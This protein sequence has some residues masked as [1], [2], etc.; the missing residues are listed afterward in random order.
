MYLGD[1]GCRHCYNLNRMQSELLRL[2]CALSRLARKLQLP[3]SLKTEANRVLARDSP[4]IVGATGM[5][6]V[7]RSFFSAML[8]PHRRRGSCGGT[9]FVR[10]LSNIRMTVCPPS[11]ASFTPLTK[12][13]RSDHD[14][15]FTSQ[16]T[17]RRINDMSSVAGPLRQDATRSRICCF[18]AGRGKLQASVAICARPSTP[19]ILR[20][21]SK[22]SL[23][24]SV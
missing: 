21:E 6:S 3:S 17:S 13:E 1:S 8:A 9:P 11:T 19:S 7:W 10:T 23:K 5:A 12:V 15:H 2:G 22:F 20:S 4:V 16:E 18:I 14:L 24:P